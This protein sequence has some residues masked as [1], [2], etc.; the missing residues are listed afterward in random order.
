MVDDVPSC[1]IKLAMTTPF[2]QSAIAPISTAILFGVVVV[3]EASVVQSLPAPFALFPLTLAAGVLASR[4][5]LLPPAV[6]ALLMSASTVIGHSRRAM[7]R[8]ECDRDPFSHCR[9]RGRSA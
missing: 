2:A 3:L 9:R 8:G 4:G 6:G 1:T 5:L 7:G